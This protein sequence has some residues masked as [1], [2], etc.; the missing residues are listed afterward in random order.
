M[1]ILE[2]QEG[3][4]LIVSVRGHLDTLGAPV[5]EDQVL[6]RVE[7]GVLS[8]ILDCSDLEYVNSAGLKSFLVIAKRVETRGGKFA[9]CALRPHITAVFATIGFDQI[10]TVVPTRQEALRLQEGESPS[11]VIAPI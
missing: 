4:L 1:Q 11:S 2:E 6:E 8:V 7:A 9:V 5:F 3:D 10:M